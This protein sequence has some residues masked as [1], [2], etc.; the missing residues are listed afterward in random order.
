MT[1]SRGNDRHIQYILEALL[2]DDQLRELAASKGVSIPTNKR[3]KAERAAFLATQVTLADI[4]KFCR[5][6]WTPPPVDSHLA[7]L[8]SGLLVG[9]SWHGAAP[10]RLHLSLQD[11][12]RRLDGSRQAL[13]DFIRVGADIARHEYYMVA[14]ADLSEYVLITRCGAFPAAKEKAL[15]DIVLG[16]VP[17]DVKNVSAPR[18]WSAEAIRDNP[19]SFAVEMIS[20][21]D[22]ERRRKQADS[23][24]S[25]ASLNRLFIVAQDEDAW[26]RKPEY[27]LNRLVEQVCKGC[28]PLTVKVDG[29]TVDVMVV[30]VP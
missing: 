6:K 12:V 30:V 22:S 10:S 19:E 18:N 7:N 26:L 4:A 13:E 3:N 14:V 2:T 9:H 28:Q 16:G 23:H 21:A 27:L 15:S 5:K 1:E 11:R 25:D 17:Y 20:G 24:N 29:R 8:K